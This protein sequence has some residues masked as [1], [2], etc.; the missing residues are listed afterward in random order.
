MGLSALDFRCARTLPTTTPNPKIR[1]DHF[2][3]EHLEHLE[4]SFSFNDLRWNI[5][6]NFVVKAKIVEQTLKINDL[7]VEQ[8][9]NLPAWVD[10][11]KKLGTLRAFAVQRS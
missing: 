10:K 4:Q 11:K 8:A 6:Q 9:K 5:C 3:V 1:S 7:G 2:G